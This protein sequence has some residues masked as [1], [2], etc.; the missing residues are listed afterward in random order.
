MEIFLSFDFLTFHPS[1]IHK[2]VHKSCW[3]FLYILSP[4]FFLLF[5]WILYQHFQAH[6]LS[7][8][9]R[10]DKRVLLSQLIQSRPWRT[11]LGYVPIPEPNPV[12]RGMVDTDWLGLRHVTVLEVRN[13]GA[14]APMKIKTLKPKEGKMSNK[15]VKATYIQ[16]TSKFKS[17][18]F[19]FGKYTMSID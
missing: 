16:C 4:S 13:G 9:Q 12:A 7:P 18:Y 3:F 19:W 11:S 6:L 1:H 5:L 14:D 17:N 10:S 8:W 15:L 2:S